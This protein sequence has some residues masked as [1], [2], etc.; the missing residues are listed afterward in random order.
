MVVQAKIWGNLVGDLF[1]K[2]DE[3]QVFF[4][5]NDEFLNKGLEIAPILMPINSR[6][7]VFTFPF[8]NQETFKNL[9]PVFSDSLPDRFGNITLNSYLQTQGKD[10]EDLNPL[11]RLTYIGER[12]IGALEYFPAQKHNSIYNGKPLD[13]SE[14]IEIA[15]EVMQQKKGVK[16]NSIE[17][18]LQIG[19]AAGGAR[20][21]IVIAKD[22]TT[23]EFY[24]GDVLNKNKEVTY[25]LLKL[26]GTTDNQNSETS[27]YGKIEFAYYQLATLSGINMSKTELLVEN[28]R[29][30]FLTQ[31]FD[32]ID[33]KKIHSQ[34]LN[35]IANLDYNNPL[36]NSYEQCFSVMRKLNLSQSEIEQQFKRMVFN[37]MSKNLDDHTKNI[38]FLMNDIGKWSLSP[39]YD[40]THSYDPNNKWLKQHQMSINGKRNNIEYNDLIEVAE[41]QMIGNTNF[42][43][44]EV[45]EGVSNWIKIAKNLDIPL[46]KTNKIEQSLEYNS[47]KPSLIKPN[48][49]NEISSD[50]KIKKSID[51]HL[52]N[53][54]NLKINNLI[55]FGEEGALNKA[56]KQNF[57]FVLNIKEL[58]QVYEKVK[59]E[60]KNLKKG[61]KF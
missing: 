6:E 22:N 42:I 13:L 37:V 56:L 32:R 18:I 38:S 14:I 31:R 23:N 35:S 59:I 17:Q 43:I 7:K 8:L 27:Q 5:Y 1:F 44:Q 11:E 20:P 26:D 19:T 12:G 25:Y 41:K 40:L 33:G 4:V 61:R 54:Y 48:K 60:N 24:A 21:K 15:K 57:G 50:E 10:I 45:Q 30:H 2:E 3:K 28:D 16:I 34:T 53:N 58:K 36:I 52:N 39:A 49:I 46:E 29:N 51:F 55:L 9:P 47:I